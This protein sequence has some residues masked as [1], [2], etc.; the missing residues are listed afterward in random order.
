V[1]LVAGRAVRTG[2][3][4]HRPAG[5]RISRAG[6]S[7]SA[8]AGGWGR[9]GRPG[10]AGRGDGSVQAAEGNVLAALTGW[11]RLGRAGRVRTGW[12]GWVRFCCGFW[13][14]CS[15]G[16]G[17]L[18]GGGQR[19]GGS[20]RA[21]TRPVGGAGWAC[22]AGADGGGGAGSTGRPGGGG[23]DRPDRRRWRSTWLG[24]GLAVA[25]VR[26]L[27]WRQGRPGWPGCRLGCASQRRDQGEGA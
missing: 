24:A 8:D 10:R 23:S 3:R 12:L 13:C 19:G 26:P 9:L 15:A 18:V 20:Q 22:A 16:G 17:V 7:S 27:A 1:G 14:L 25:A 6:G 21:G 2:R 5:H 4:Q 11:C